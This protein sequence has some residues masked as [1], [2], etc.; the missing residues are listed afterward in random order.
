MNNPR[1]LIG[2]ANGLEYLH[3]AGVTHGN[4]KGVCHLATYDM[5]EIR[6]ETFAV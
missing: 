1:Q 5:D 6:V 4:L 2:V 3:R